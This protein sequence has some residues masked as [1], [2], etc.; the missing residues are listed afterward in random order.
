MINNENAKLRIN[1][2]QSSDQ[3][4]TKYK[5]CYILNNLNNYQ[6][7]VIIGSNTKTNEINK[8][9]EQNNEK[10]KTL[11][12]NNNNQNSISNNTSDNNSKK[13][14]GAPN[15]NNNDIENNSLIQSAGN[16]LNT[17]AFSLNNNLPNENSIQAGNYVKF[18]GLNG[19]GFNPI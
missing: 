2:A 9:L 18:N 3:R 1:N 10:I 17:I 4:S 6:P 5:N 12:Y 11:N 15:N 14:N 19:N 7:N 16:C 8:N 13:T